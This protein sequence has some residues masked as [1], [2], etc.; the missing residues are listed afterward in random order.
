MHEAVVF[1]GITHHSAT[2]ETTNQAPESQHGVNSLREA[3][4]DI[5]S[6]DDDESD[7]GRTRGAPNTSARSRPIEYETFDLSSITQSDSDTPEER[8]V[9]D[10]PVAAAPVVNDTPAA[11]ATDNTPAAQDIVVFANGTRA[12]KKKGRGGSRG[13]GAGRGGQA[14]AEPVVVQPRRVSGRTRTS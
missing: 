9:D 2:S 13:R 5:D 3:L 14:G 6:S 11:P 12:G 4:R 8:N 7:D 10:T 1:E